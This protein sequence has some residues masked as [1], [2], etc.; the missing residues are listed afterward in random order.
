MYFTTALAFFEDSGWYFA[1]YSDS[2]I[3]PFGYG[4]GCDF[5]RKPCLVKNGEDESAFVPS[6]SRG[7]FCGES[8]AGCSPSSRY[9]MWCGFNPVGP[10]S[11]FQ[12]FG[13][14]LLGGVNALLDY[15]PVYS[16][17]FL[18]DD[19]GYII[20]HDN[21]DCREPTNSDANVP[22]LYQEEFGENSICVDTN[23]RYPIC[24]KH[25]CDAT[26]QKLSI[27]A[28]GSWYECKEDFDIIYPYATGIDPS[29]TLICPR[30]SM[31]CPNLFCPH[32][33]EG[34]GKCNWDA[35]GG[36]RCECFDASDTSEICSERPEPAGTS[37]TGQH[38]FK[39]MLWFSATIMITSI[40]LY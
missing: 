26:T 13:N 1:N 30:I 36:A 20:D 24:Y 19:Q 6:Y 40:S 31:A 38:D 4:A 37:S 32:N 28:F 7:S 18:S 35:E 34:R 15:C 8:A 25:K 2:E 17:A 9:K 3:S 29:F 11:Q 21:H 10:P 16:F 12:Y 5:V 22:S 39:M 33:C 14:P 23:F 27:G